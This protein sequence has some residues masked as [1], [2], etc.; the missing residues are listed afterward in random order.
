MSSLSDTQPELHPVN[1]STRRSFSGRCHIENVGF[2]AP[3][4]KFVADVVCPE[5]GAKSRVAADTIDG[6]EKQIK[7]VFDLYEWR[8]NRR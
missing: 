8:L 3:M 2:Y 6:L 1:V 7:S 4:K 5:T